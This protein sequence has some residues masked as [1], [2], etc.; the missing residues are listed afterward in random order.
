MLAGAALTFKSTRLLNRWAV[1]RVAAPASREPA[2][3]NGWGPNGPGGQRCTTILTFDNPSRCA[4]R[5]KT[6]ALS[7]CNLMQPAEAGRPSLLML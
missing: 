3:A 5:N 1:L 6:A 4:I 2:P 7:G